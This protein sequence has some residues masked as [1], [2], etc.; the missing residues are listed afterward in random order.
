MGRTWPFASFVGASAR[1]TARFLGAVTLAGLD[2]LYAQR[3]ACSPS[4]VTTD[5]PSLDTAYPPQ[6]RAVRLPSG[7]APP[8]GVRYLA[9][10]GGH[11][12]RAV[13]LY[14]FRGAAP[15]GALALA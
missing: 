4:A 14:G 12:P 9:Q 15:T 6:M 11:H 7:G 1:Y 10:G 2:S 5:P 3:M 8:N 13:L